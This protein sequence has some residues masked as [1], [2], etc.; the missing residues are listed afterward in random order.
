MAY[1][2]LYL[3]LNYNQK[4]LF[5][6]AIIMIVLTISIITK[7]KN[8]TKKYQIRHIRHIQSKNDFR[9]DYDVFIKTYFEK[10]DFLGENKNRKAELV[11]M[12]S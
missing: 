7:I 5:A 10:E 8:K 1:P 6:I 4:V 9:I 3:N 12:F 2:E 11:R